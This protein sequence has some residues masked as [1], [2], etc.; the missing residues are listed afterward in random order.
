MQVG[1]TREL[2]DALKHARAGTTVVD[3]VLD[4]KG[5]DWLICGNRVSNPP[6]AT[7][8]EEGVADAHRP[9]SCRD[10]RSAGSLRVA[11]VG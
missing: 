9:W 8:A 3:S 1:T 5:N 4:T 11:W 7:A 2:T 6:R 10:G